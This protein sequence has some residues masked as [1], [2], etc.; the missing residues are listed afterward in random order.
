MARQALV[1]VEADVT[2]RPYQQAASDAAVDWMR[3]SVEPAVI[4]A[5]T[6]AGKSHVIADMALLEDRI[7]TIPGVRA[8]ESFVYLKLSK[9]TY[10]WGTR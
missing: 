1:I 8:T 3:R 6:A 2:L 7:R 9:Q 10:Q 4:E 5:V